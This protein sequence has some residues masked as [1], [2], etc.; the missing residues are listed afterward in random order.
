MVERNFCWS[1]HVADKFSRPLS[2][3]NVGKVTLS[4]VRILERELHWFRTASLSK[5]GIWVPSGIWLNGESCSQSAPC[6]PMASAVRQSHQCQISP[7]QKGYL[8][9]STSC[10]WLLSRFR[11]FKN[12]VAASSCSSRVCSLPVSPRMSVQRWFG[13]WRSIF[14]LLCARC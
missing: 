2:V 3:P 11:K 7:C 6:L 10:A 4:L 9:S 13:N 1:W 14:N 5:H 12:F 8:S